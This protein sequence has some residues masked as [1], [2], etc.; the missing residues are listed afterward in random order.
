MSQYWCL[1][2]GGYG[3]GWI[4]RLIGWREDSKMAL[5]SSSPGRMDP[6]KSCCQCLCPQGRGCKLPPASL[7]AF[8]RSAGGSAPPGDC[9]MTTSALIL[10]QVRLCVHPLKVDSIPTALWDS[11]KLSHDL[12]RQ[13]FWCTV[14][15][16]QDRWPWGP[17]VGLRPFLLG[18]TSVIAILLLSV[19]CPPGCMALDCTVTPPS[20]LIVVPSLCI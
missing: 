9:Q 5:T 12:Q 18:R 15:P 7:G 10:E 19:G 17:E 11:Q 13:T 20:C 16:A 6:P 14:F 1:W 4:L 2:A 8:S 3:W